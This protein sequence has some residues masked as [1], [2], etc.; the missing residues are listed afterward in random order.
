MIPGMIAP[1]V[2]GF[3]SS[4]FKKRAIDYEGWLFGGTYDNSWMELRK[5]AGK[6][7]LMPRAGARGWAN[8]KAELIFRARKDYNLMRS[9]VG[10]PKI[11]DWSKRPQKLIQ[12]MDF[13]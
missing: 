11:T 3:M 5:K 13:K 1:L 8:R 7:H 10:L 9:E 6:D 2:K 12:H 4:W